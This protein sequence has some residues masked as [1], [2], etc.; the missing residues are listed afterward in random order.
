VDVDDWRFRP[1]ARRAAYSICAAPRTLTIAATVACNF[2]GSTTVG[3]G[4]Q[5]IKITA[6]LPRRFDE[7]DGQAIGQGD[8]TRGQFDGG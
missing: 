5:L 2:A 1:A 4:G 8:L 7:D 6:G 3:F